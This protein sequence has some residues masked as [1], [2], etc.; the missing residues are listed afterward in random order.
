MTPSDWRRLYAIRAA[1]KRKGSRKAYG[2]PPKH[3]H[4]RRPR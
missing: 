2:K 4:K 1:R 3:G